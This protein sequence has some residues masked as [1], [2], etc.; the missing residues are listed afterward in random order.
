MDLYVTHTKSAPM[1]SVQ[2]K[3]TTHMGLKSRFH[4]RS[5][6]HQQNVWKCSYSRQFYVE[7]DQQ[8]RTEEV[9]GWTETTNNRWNG[10]SA[11]RFP[12]REVLEARNEVRVVI[13]CRHPGV[14]R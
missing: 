6:P 1:S 7:Q 4:I 8:W 14:H 3:N 13:L 9:S 2:A 11:E 5:L 12:Y 10:C